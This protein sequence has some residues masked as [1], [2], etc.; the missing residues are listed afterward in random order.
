MLCVQEKTM[1]PI[2][3]LLTLV[4]ALAVSLP[5]LSAPPRGGG[6][7]GGYRGGGGGH[8]HG[9]G[10]HYNGNRW[11]VGV[12]FGFP[13]YPY[14]GYYPGFYGGYY[15]YYPYNPYPAYYPAPVA[16]QQQPMVYTEQPAPQAQQ[17][18]PV[19]YWYYCANPGAY[20][21]YVRECPAGW[22]RVAPQPSN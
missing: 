11:V 5:A 2:R 17:Q 3:I 21:P 22:Q 12:N 1:T 13:G 7:G 10:G 14:F 19:G 18:G 6:G 4:L 20:Y 16:V 9:G 8:Y 15:P